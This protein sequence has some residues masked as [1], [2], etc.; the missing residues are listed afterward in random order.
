MNLL[1]FWFAT[2]ES[3][4]YF[5]IGAAV[6]TAILAWLMPGFNPLWSARRS[7]VKPG[8]AVPVSGVSNPSPQDTAEFKRVETQP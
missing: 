4:L 2:A 1:A 3:R 6:F 5:A 8:V 7:A